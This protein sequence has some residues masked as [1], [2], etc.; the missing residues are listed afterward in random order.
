MRI[1]IYSGGRLRSPRRSIISSP[2]QRS[3][4]LPAAEADY[5]SLFEVGEALGALLCS[6][7]IGQISPVPTHSLIPCQTGSLIVGTRLQ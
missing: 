7:P 1:E 2:R 6:N 4:S 5:R 3:A